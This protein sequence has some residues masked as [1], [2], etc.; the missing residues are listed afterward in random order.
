M[1]PL[2]L[3]LITIGAAS[4]IG[5]AWLGGYQLGLSNG[6]R[7]PRRQTVA[8]LINELPTRRAKSAKNRRKAARRA[9]K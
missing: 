4:L 5:M 7:A 1:D 9:S 8:E 3:I 6:Q 2:N